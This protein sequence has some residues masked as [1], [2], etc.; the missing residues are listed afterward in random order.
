MDEIPNKREADAFLDH[1]ETRFIAR[2]VTL[3]KNETFDY[4]IERTI[5]VQFKKKDGST[6]TD[7]RTYNIF[8]SQLICCKSW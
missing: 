3:F 4:G 2:N 1:N 6:K 5:T 7:Q 8:I